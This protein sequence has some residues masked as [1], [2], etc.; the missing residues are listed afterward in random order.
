MKFTAD[1]KAFRSALALAGK[2]IQNKSPIPVVLCV[3]LVTNDNRVSVFGTDLDMSFEVTVPAEVAT[4]GVTVISFA[5][6]NAF[7]AAAKTD[8]V[9]IDADSKAATVTAG[10]SRIA[11]APVDPREFP[12]YL[13]AEGDL[14]TLDGPTICAALR[15]AAATASD[16]EVQYYLQG[17]FVQERGDGLHIWGTDGH[18]M[19]HIAL[20]GLPA[21]GGG[22]IVPADAVAIIC[23]M[24]EKTADFGLMISE[25]GWHAKA[26]LVR[27][28][29]KVIE[30]TFPDC[31]RVIDGFNAWGDFLVSGKDE[32]ASAL[33]VAACGADTTNKARSLIIKASE[34]EP[35]IVRGAR[36]AS[37]IISAGRAM[38]DTR[39]NGTAA[40]CV[41][42]ELITRSIAAMP[43]EEIVIAACGETAVRVRP[44]Q[45]NAVSSAEAIIMGIRATEA[46]FADA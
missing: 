18:S 44:A 25:R 36:G 41:S 10:K 26:G 22:G 6:L 8:S 29:G 1:M 21:I 34:D 11:I 24:G 13:P 5:A 16:S 14:V 4:E 17:P 45:A 12:N 19:H 15:F 38:T 37:G 40:V 28:W 9:T 3:K 23:Q 31:Q 27:A 43:G 33:T 20:P 2:V 46:E 39:A 7:C 32:I 35:V 42:A 30:G